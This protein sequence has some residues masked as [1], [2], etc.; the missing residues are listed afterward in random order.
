MHAVY[1]CMH[2]CCLIMTGT[3]HNWLGV[4]S[5]PVACGMLTLLQ[6]SIR[7]LS[8][9]Y[10]LHTMAKPP[11]CYMLHAM[12]Y[13]APL[14]LL[15]QCLFCAMQMMHASAWKAVFIYGMQL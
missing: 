4:S 7:Q 2:A 6:Y 12:V 8:C 13:Y 5:S 14:M 10:M 15:C 11:L 1:A 3:H 9:V